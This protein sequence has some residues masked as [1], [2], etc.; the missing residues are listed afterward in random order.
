MISPTLGISTSSFSD[1]LVV[2]SGIISQTYG[3]LYNNDQID[4]LYMCKVTS[5]WGLEGLYIHDP[6]ECPYV[7]N[8]GGTA[9]YVKYYRPRTHASYTISP[10]IIVYRVCVKTSMG[11]PEK[12]AISAS[13][14]TSRLPSLSETPQISAG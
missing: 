11:L 6:L 10:S 4:N 8:Y 13:F 7:P 14:P 9:D 5:K 2:H 3:W 1:D 12:M